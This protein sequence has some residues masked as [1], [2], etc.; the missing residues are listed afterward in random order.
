MRTA[1]RSREYRQG[2]IGRYRTYRCRSCGGK[3]QVFRLESLPEKER[4]CAICRQQKEVT[5]ND[6][7]A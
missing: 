1:T 6:I 5:N 4:I 7:T 2:I 3:F